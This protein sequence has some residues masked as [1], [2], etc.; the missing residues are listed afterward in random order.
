MSPAIIF[1]FITTVGLIGLAFGDDSIFRLAP[2]LLVTGLSFASTI[3]FSL[4][5]SHQRSVMGRVAELPI[6]KWLSPTSWVIA[7]AIMILITVLLC[8]SLDR[9]QLV[10]PEAID[11]VMTF[12]FASIAA[13][14]IYWALVGGIR[15]L[16]QKEV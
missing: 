16:G 1:G 4:K 12:S 7:T 13:L 3:I 14:V 11:I 15:Y 6:P 8:L 5:N 2:I 10:G 9:W